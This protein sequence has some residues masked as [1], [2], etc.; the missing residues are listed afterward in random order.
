MV[1]AVVA[2]EFTNAMHEVPHTENSARMPGANWREVMIDLHCGACGRE[3][4]GNAV[5]E[6][7]PFCARAL[8]AEQRAA[9]ARLRDCIRGRNGSQLGLTDL[10]TLLQIVDTTASAV[11]VLRAI[12]INVDARITRIP[13][14]LLVDAHEEVRSAIAAKRP[15]LPLELDVL[16]VA[17]H[18]IDTSDSADDVAVTTPTAVLRAMLGLAEGAK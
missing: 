14:S 11:E 17:H 18:Y 9:V 3:W 2:D 1:C 8:T 10:M 13:R 16:N 4:R 12:V 6:P 15:L 5:T 7:C